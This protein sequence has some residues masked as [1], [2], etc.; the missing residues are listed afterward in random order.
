MAIDKLSESL[1]MPR[2]N[3]FTQLDNDRLLLNVLG[4]LKMTDSVFSVAEHDFEEVLAKLI[5]HWV[6]TRLVL[7]ELFAELFV[8][9][10][11]KYV[12]NLFDERLRLICLCCLIILLYLLF[13]HFF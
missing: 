2:L 11:S 7:L 6:H 12:F 8:L 4:N 3:L 1:T 5:D 13:L 9:L 10:F